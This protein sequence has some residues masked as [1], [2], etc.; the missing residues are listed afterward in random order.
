MAEF[1]I[2][3]HKSKYGYDISCPTLQGCHSQGATKEEAIENIRDAIREYLAALRQMK[4]RQKLLKI[5]VAV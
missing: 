4:R 5:K 1:L 2:Q 3:I